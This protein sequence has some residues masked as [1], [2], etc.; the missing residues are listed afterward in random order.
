M[1]YTDRLEKSLMDIQQLNLSHPEHVNI[2]V[3]NGVL[4]CHLTPAG[5]WLCCAEEAAQICARGFTIE[6]AAANWERAQELSE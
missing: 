1:M 4:A 3:Q 6:L 2:V 5:T